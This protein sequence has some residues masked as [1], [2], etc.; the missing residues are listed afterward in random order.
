MPTP[1]DIPPTDFLRPGELSRGPDIFRPGTAGWV[2]DTTAKT[3]VYAKYPDPTGNRWFREPCSVGHEHIITRP[4][5]LAALFGPDLETVLAKVTY[6]KP[7]YR[8]DPATGFVA[9]GPDGPVVLGHESAIDHIEVRRLSRDTNLYGRAGHL[10]GRHVVR[11]WLAC[12][13]WPGLLDAALPLLGA[14]PETVVTTPSEQFTVEVY[15]RWR[16]GRA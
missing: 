9:T 3:F 4:N 10:R 13:G 14:G 15:R 11:L 7:V 16:E 5:V 1:D 2:G 6:Q 12:E 8:T